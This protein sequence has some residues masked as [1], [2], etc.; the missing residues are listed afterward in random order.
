[1]SRK[2]SG[3]IG[4]KG[5]APMRIGIDARLGH[6]EGVGRHIKELV[7]WAA[8]VDADNEYVVYIKA[9]A[10]EHFTGEAFRRPNL[11]W[12]HLKG[13]SFLAGEQIDLVRALYRDRLDLFHATFDYGIPIAAPCKQVLTVHDAWFGPQTYFRSDWTRR[14]YQFMTRLGLRRAE[15]VVAVS[16]F[17]KEKVLRFYPRIKLSKAKIRVIHNGVGEEF[18]T[19]FPS[20]FP[21]LERY[22][23]EK[24][25]LYVGA[26]T[27]HK[28]IFGI[29]EGY[30]ELVRRYPAAPPLV[31]GGKANPNL[32]D[33][34]AF[35]EKRGIGKKVF[36]L[37][38]VPEE[39]L[40]ALYRGAA[41]FIFPSLHEGFGIPVLE[42]MACG[43]PVVTANVAAMPE[44]AGDAALLVN[45]N[46]PEEIQAAMASVLF[47]PGLGKGLAERG[48]ARAK[49]F[50]WKKM[51]LEVLDVYRKVYE[52]N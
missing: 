48:I 52:K 8:A 11:R 5:S 21:L 51:T 30:A 24:Y 14:Y 3:S 34:R 37:G 49:A 35:A 15:G 19:A 39:A 33:P 4:S 7:R 44:V 12:V 6:K 32:A 17:V 29:L 26:L 43:T 36:F 25:L 1:M 23:I 28:N 40:P 22:G 13:D 45:P 41:L 9:K 46:R 2:G 31:I 42:A 27:E 50:S 38:F 20:S 16:R 47:E 10:A 18:N